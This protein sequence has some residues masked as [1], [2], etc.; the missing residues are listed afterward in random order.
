M[1]EL[2]LNTD[3]LSENFSQLIEITFKQL[4]TY[5]TFTRKY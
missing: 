5:I 2:H 4:P 1:R 3:K